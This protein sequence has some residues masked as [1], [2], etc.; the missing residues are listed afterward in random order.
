MGDFFLALWVKQKL[1][2][3][4]TFYEGEPGSKDETSPMVINPWHLDC[5][6]QKRKKKS[7]GPSRTKFDTIV[8]SGVCVCVFFFVKKKNASVLFQRT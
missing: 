3:Q 5:C 2:I 6:A 8:L 4:V 1:C 7:S